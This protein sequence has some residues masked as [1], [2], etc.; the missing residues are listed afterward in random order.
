MEK[1]LILGRSLRVVVL[2]G[3]TAASMVNSF[4]APTCC[5]S[6]VRNG[7]FFEPPIRLLDD[8]LVLNETGGSNNKKKKR[9]RRKAPVS[10]SADL[11]P[12]EQ[13][14]KAPALSTNMD[15]EPVD[16][17]TI[18]D[19]ANFNFNSNEGFSEGWWLGCLV[20]VAAMIDHSPE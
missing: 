12:P 13:D 16:L 19:V 15:D 1:S 17:G 10:P 8:S 2:I 14:K 7:N 4:V 3:L 5:S 18:S 9:R 6:G 11:I 20:F